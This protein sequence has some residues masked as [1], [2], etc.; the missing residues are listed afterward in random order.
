MTTA[1]TIQQLEDDATQRKDR[2]AA[3]ASRTESA[4]V[5]AQEARALLAPSP[6]VLKVNVRDMLPEERAEL[7]A[8]LHKVARRLLASAADLLPASNDLPDGDPPSP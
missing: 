5:V 1:E 7:A 6:E 2:Y 3:A 8:T 4:R